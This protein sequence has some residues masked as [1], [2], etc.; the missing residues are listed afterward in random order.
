MAAGLTRCCWKTRRHAIIA[1]LLFEQRSCQW[2]LWFHYKM[3]SS[4]ISMYLHLELA[5][6]YLPATNYDHFEGK[7]VICNRNLAAD[8][9]WLIA[10]KKLTFCVWNTCHYM[11]IV[12][13]EITNRIKAVCLVHIG[14]PPYTH[15][16]DFIVSTGQQSLSQHLICII[17]IVCATL[18]W[19]YIAK[20]L[21]F[22]NFLANSFFFF[23]HIIYLPNK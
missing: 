12:N 18:N 16:Y 14:I 10:I 17:N 23:Y 21:N 8:K 20:F 7:H 19:I 4:L 5:L 2:L 15:A 11:L 13:S 22:Y 1:Y 9:S 3:L 6:A